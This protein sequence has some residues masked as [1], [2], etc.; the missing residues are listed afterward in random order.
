M[1]A[2]RY[3]LERFYNNGKLSLKEV[4]DMVNKREISIK[5]FHYITNYNYY[6]IAKTKN[7]ETKY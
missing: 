5:D 2:D 3:V 1:R 7:W 4:F 6:G